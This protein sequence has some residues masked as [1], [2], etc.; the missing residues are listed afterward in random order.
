MREIMRLIATTIIWGAFISV[1]GISLT[2]VT[3]P[4]AQ[5]N[6]GEVVALMAI[7]MSGAIAMTYAVWHSGFNVGRA[8]DYAGSEGRGKAKRSYPDRVERLIEELDDDM[9]YELEAL[10]LARDREARERSQ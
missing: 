1:A 5:M 2:G 4:I 10:L 3:G 8:G 7:F 9:V 6:G